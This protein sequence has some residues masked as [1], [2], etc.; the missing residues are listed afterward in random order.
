MKTTLQVLA[1]LNYARD[2][3]S[4][5]GD[6]EELAIRLL[7]AKEDLMKL[8]LGGFARVTDNWEGVTREYN[9]LIT[10]VMDYQISEGVVHLEVEDFN[11]IS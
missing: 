6:I 4:D 9:S 11:P 1:D 8:T 5:E 3:F 10:E 2:R 7:Y